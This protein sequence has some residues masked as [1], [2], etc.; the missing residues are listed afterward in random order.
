MPDFI[1][2]LHD[3][4]AEGTPAAADDYAAMIQEYMAWTDKIRNSGHHKQGEK[5]TDDA[6]KVLRGAGPVTVTDGP[7]AESKEIVGGFYIISAK[8]Y[9][10]ACKVA[11]GSPH[12]KFSGSI[13]VRQI[14]D[15]G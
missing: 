14:H 13:E 7:F 8:D 15:L 3:S 5:L 9:D 11:Q 12:L 4:G 2:L 1:L 6:G 10:E